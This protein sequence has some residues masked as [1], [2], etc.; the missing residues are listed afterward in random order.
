MVEEKKQLEATQKR[1]D[2]FADWYTTIEHKTFQGTI[3]C[4]NMVD[5]LNSKRIIEVGCGPGLHSQ[6]IAK[7]FMSKGS[8]LVSCD[9]ST[10]MV[11]KMKA[12]YA[13]SDLSKEGISVQFDE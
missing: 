1:Y 3:T 4:L 13:A 2:S 11:N 6:L 8:L 5:S 10:E 12:R 9:F 7:S